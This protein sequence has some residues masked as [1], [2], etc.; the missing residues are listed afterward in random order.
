MVM[1][2][3]ATPPAAASHSVSCSPPRRLGVAGACSRGPAPAGPRRPPQVRVPPTRAALVEATRQTPPVVV[4][5]GGAAGTDVGRYSIQL[6]DR[7]NGAASSPASLRDRTDDMQ[8]ETRALGRAVGA[9][10]YSPELLAEKYGSR[11]IKVRIPIPSPILLPCVVRMA[12]A[13]RHL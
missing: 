13:V 8:A 12:S 11:P 6:A 1:V 7:G 2:V 5:Q 3:V 9:T 4:R 10:V